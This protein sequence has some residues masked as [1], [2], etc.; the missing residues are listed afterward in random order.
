MTKRG[1]TSF[2]LQIEIVELATS[3]SSL[4]EHR[5]KSRNDKYSPEWATPVI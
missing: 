3:D 1:S 2:S 4:N 5:N